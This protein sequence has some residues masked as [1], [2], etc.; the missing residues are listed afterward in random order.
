M[1]S[2]LTISLSLSILLCF[3]M[4]SDQ[5]DKDEILFF[6]AIARHGART[7]ANPEYYQIT[8]DES[9]LKN[10]GRLT[11]VGKH[12]LYLLGRQLADKYIRQNKVLSVKYNPNQ[13]IARA[14]GINRTIESAQ[15]LLMGLYPPGTGPA[16]S[17]EEIEAAVPPIKVEHLEEIQAELREAALPFYAR[18]IP[19]RTA[20]AVF[21]YIFAPHLECDTIAEDEE[22]YADEFKKIDEKYNDYYPLLKSRYNLTVKDTVDVYKL[23]DNVAAALGNAIKLKI[24]FTEEDL[25]T[26]EAI[27]VDENI[28]VFVKSELKVKL[29]CHMILYDLRRHLMRVV[30][31]DKNNVPHDQR[32]RFAL[33][34]V[35]DAHIMA[36]S[37]ILPITIDTYIKFASSL[38]FEL[39]KITDHQKN[40]QY[41]IK[42]FYNTQEQDFS[43][44][45]LYKYEKFVEYIKENAFEDDEDFLDNCFSEHN[46]VDYDKEEFTAITVILFIVFLL[47][48]G[49]N[50]WALT[51]KPKEEEPTTTSSLTEPTGLINETINEGDSP[52]KK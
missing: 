14:S 28:N 47:I 23:Y 20:T 49:A 4:G 48:W 11:N 6:S 35:S 5:A 17:P 12:Q 32:L 1:K 8:D 30:E 3:S 50:W 39:H 10:P 40:V 46:P 9:F 43:K 16:L 52:T 19:L 29:L 13:I 21:D 22:Q 44:N 25:E 36:L 26:L 24:N 42:V 34:H 38:I 31:E 33:F 2:I 41:H 15:S 37:K 45:D 51:R 18:T 7:M 27:T